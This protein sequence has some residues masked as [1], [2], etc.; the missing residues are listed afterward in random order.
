MACRGVRSD[1]EMVTSRLLGAMLTRQSTRAE[2]LA[3]ERA[4]H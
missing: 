3:L 2:F 4:G 1:A